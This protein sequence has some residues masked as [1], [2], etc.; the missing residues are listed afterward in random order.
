MNTTRSWNDDPAANSLTG[1]DD[2]IVTE[3][4]ERKIAGLLKHLVSVRYVSV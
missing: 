3:L 1:H 2:S 4:G